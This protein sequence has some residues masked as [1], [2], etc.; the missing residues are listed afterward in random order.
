[1]P[2]KLEPGE[3]G[4]VTRGTTYEYTDLE[5]YRRLAHAGVMELTWPQFVSQAL[6]HE[7]ARYRQEEKHK[8]GGK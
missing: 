2:K 3:I 5:E 8:K 7:L 6:K 1:M 4:S